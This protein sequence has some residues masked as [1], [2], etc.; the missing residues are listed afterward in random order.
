[1]QDKESN[2]HLRSALDQRFSAMETER[3]SFLPHWQELADFISPR[4]ARINKAID[5]GKGNKVNQKI[6]DPT[7]S[8]SLRTLKS[9]LMAGLTSPSRPWF[10]L[11]TT[12]PEL[13]KSAA[14][15]NYLFTVESKLRESFTKSN[16]Y[17][18]L[19][20]VYGDL[21]MPGT[22]AMACLEDDR[23][24]LRFYPYQ[25]GT[26]MIA[27][28]PYMHVDTF[29]MELS[30]TVQ[31]VVQEFGL[32]NCS[33][34]VQGMWASN[35]TQTQ[36]IVR[37]VVEPNDDRTPG[38][39]DAK[40]KPFRS[41]Y[42]EKG[43]SGDLF[44]RQSGFDEFPIMAPRWDI[45]NST[46][47]YGYS[48]A[49]DAL[50]MVRGLQ[51]EHKSK[52]QAI[53]K[54]VNP[55]ML[56]DAGLRNQLGSVLPGGVTYIDG[57][58]QQQHASM[59][60]LEQD[61]PN[62]EH[63]KMDIEDVRH[64]IQRCFFEDM[65]QMLASSD[66][67]EMTAREIE[68]RHSEKV[69]VLGPV[70]ERMNDELFDPLIERSYNILLRKGMLPKPPPEMQGQNLKIEY[71]SIMAQAMKLMGIGNDDRLMEGVGRAAQLDPKALDK[72]DVDEWIDGYADKLGTNP[73]IIRTL[74]QVKALRDMR[75]KQQQA[76][77]MAQ[78]AKPA[79]QMA[80]AGKAMGETDPENVQKLVGMMTGAK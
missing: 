6:I 8:L 5:N 43:G 39:L 46:D 17:M 20:M 64:L 1:M 59:R 3:T 62:I 31:Q 61:L 36:V 53:D 33:G 67:P 63:L 52:Y 47:A 69:L 68:E 38:M 30:K 11:A 9:G 21:G 27:M 73:K 66:N 51:K 78:M 77:Q 41:A 60:R 14:V 45:F 74:D 72:L 18:V 25:C 2:I 71:T 49:M 55:H 34:A 7:A 44:L 57:L 42:Y 58:A 48:P 12:D 37:Y 10:K 26:Y 15:K 19:P 32:K 4:V 75:A 65:M 50:G 35:Q 76:A 13:G 54:Y 80:K 24:T 16:L 28:N 23:Q 40:N 79:E 29:Y 56:A 70:M 22:A